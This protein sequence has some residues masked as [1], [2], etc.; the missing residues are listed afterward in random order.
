M[1]LLNILNARSLDD[2]YL[3]PQGEVKLRGCDM[4]SQ[5]NSFFETVHDSLFPFTS[6]RQNLE[7]TV[8][9]LLFCAE[10]QAASAQKV[11]AFS[12][13]RHFF[14]KKEVGVIR[15][16]ELAWIRKNECVSSAG[17]NSGGAYFLHDPKDFQKKIGV[18]KVDEASR[19]S[20]SRIMLWVKRFLGQRFYLSSI[21]REA[22]AE[23]AAYHLE[24]WLKRG[25]E[26]L[27]PNCI[28][29]VHLFNGV[30]GSFQAF[31]EG[32]G[33]R[34]SWL[35]KGSYEK[36]EKIVF[37]FFAVVDYA[38]GNLDRHLDNW[39]VELGED[40]TLSRIHAID[41][42]NTFPE[43]SHAPHFLFSFPFSGPPAH[44]YAWADLK[45]AQ[46]PFE[47]EVIQ[48]ISAAFSKEKESE[49]ISFLQKTVPGFFTPLMNDELRS[50]FAVLRKIIE[51]KGLSSDL[52][53]YRSNSAVQEF[54]G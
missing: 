6:Y 24:K 43:R 39:F 35:D 46:E 11:A 44:Q 1:S 41:N 9:D 14:L 51:V 23:K 26:H 40:N 19:S 37:Q 38:L 8:V 50:R 54:L 25:F 4:L 53:S 49:V 27:A 29:D 2:L 16:A 12:L 20:F 47:E 15:K 13:T 45:I 33:D 7:N 5:L 21:H 32:Y 34:D 10:D 30:E 48:W 17:G 3:D 42:A 18:F 36:R 31:V 22:A 28:P 52:R